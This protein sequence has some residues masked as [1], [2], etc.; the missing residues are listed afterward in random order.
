VTVSLCISIYATHGLPQRFPANV[1]RV[2]SYVDDKVA[3]LTKCEYIDHPITETNDLCPIG[4]TGIKPTWFV[5]GD[6]H[7]WAAH[8]AFANWLSARGEA[9]YFAFR[10]SCPP[11]FDVHIFGDR[12]ACFEFNRNAARFI[13]AHPELANIGM[14]ST[15]R[16]ALEGALSRSPQVYAGKNESLEIFKQSFANTLERLHNMGR[17]IFVWEPVPGAKKSPPLE[18]ARAK[19]AGRTPNLERSLS[20]YRT[21]YKFFFDA[22]QEDRKW[23]YE[24]F[25]PAQALCRTGHCAA[26]TPDGRPLYTDGNHITKST[27][28]FWELI[29][30]DGRPVTDQPIPD[31]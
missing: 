23:I 22:L 28:D 3:D 2:A 8:D 1:V 30:E 24:T 18:L 20:E 29:L 31:G 27:A 14:I 16:E 25:S 9:G 13:E 17:R 21:E 26:V 7:A 12:G 19:L 5:F 10:H 15:W 4:A 6:S 11:L